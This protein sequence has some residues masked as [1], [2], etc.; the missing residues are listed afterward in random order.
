MM[1]QVQPLRPGDPPA[2]GPYRLAG[3]LARGGQGT[4]Y[5]AHGPDGLPVAIKMP[6]AQGGADA[7]EM[8]LFLKEAEIASRVAQFCTAR[9]LDAGLSAECL[10][11]VVNEY[12]DGPSLAQQVQERGPLTVDELTRLA[13]TT[14]TGLTAVHQAGIVHRDLKP[15]NIL[16]ATDG[17]RII[18]FGIARVLDTTSTTASGVIGTP[19]YM[20]PEQFEGKRI[21]SATDMFGWAATLVFAATGA[22]P[23]GSGSP[24]AILNRVLHHAP[25]LSG[26]PA[27]LRPALA[28]CLAKDPGARP[29]AHEAYTLVLRPQRTAVA[30]TAVPPIAAGHM[31]ADRADGHFLTTSP[32]PQDTTAKRSRRTAVLVGA[33]ALGATVAAGIVLALP[34][35]PL[36]GPS[37]GP[38]AQT[39]PTTAQAKPAAAWGRKLGSWQV[40]DTTAALAE[41]ERRDQVNRLFSKEQL[42][43]GDYSVSVQVQMVYLFADDAD[44]RYGLLIEQAVPP[45]AGGKSGSMA[46]L[47]LNPSE[48]DVIIQGSPDPWLD[49][50]DGMGEDRGHLTEAWDFTKIHRLEIIKRGERFEY[51]LNGV[52]MGTRTLKHGRTPMTVSLYAKGGKIGFTNFRVS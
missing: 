6:N 34:H 16:M 50:G 21:S 17:P 31:K 43:R 9:V 23:F 46:G 10:P 18:D 27:A 20:A 36:P 26:V 51:R 7:E 40:A 38:R 1:P 39:P 25:D 44:C 52:R 24:V 3:F 12:I 37:G 29:S 22:P 11:Y 48:D 35:P 33:A 45:G 41:P 49:N 14:A 15:S 19:A 2:L 30:G 47:M 32:H 28:A 42:P 13:L 4:V 8:Q 5:L